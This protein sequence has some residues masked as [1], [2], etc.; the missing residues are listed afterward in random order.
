MRRA[1]D[2][3]SSGAASA[4]PESTG[5]RATCKRWIATLADRR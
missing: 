1:S 4:I 3:R 2:R 5:W